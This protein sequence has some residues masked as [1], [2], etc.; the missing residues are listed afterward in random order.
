M[1]GFLVGFVGW[2]TFVAPRAYLVST[3]CS[4][5][6]AILAKTKR[7]GRTRFTDMSEMNLAFLLKLAWR[8][9]SQAKP[10]WYERDK[11]WWHSLK[12]KVLGVFI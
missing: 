12:A 5:T 4:V 11:G 1:S 8:I 9:I 10:C 7:F 3:T 6:R 2:R